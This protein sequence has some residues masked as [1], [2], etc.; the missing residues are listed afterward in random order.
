MQALPAA[1]LACCCTRLRQQHWRK[2][3]LTRVPIAAIAM[4]EARLAGDGVVVA[5]VM[6]PAVAPA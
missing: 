3:P 6:R 5:C 1:T 4:E 2:A